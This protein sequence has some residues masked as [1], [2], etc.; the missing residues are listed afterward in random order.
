[1]SGNM[2]YIK[3]KAI[4]AHAYLDESRVSAHDLAHLAFENDLSKIIVS[5]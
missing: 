3:I 5:Q 1:M 4:D 2:E